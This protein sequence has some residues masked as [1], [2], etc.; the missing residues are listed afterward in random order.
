MKLPEG[1]ILVQFDG[2]CILCSRTI[3]WIMKADR[4]Q[5]F[6][7]Q[8]LPNSGTAEPAESVIVWDRKKTYTHFEAIL[9]IAEELGG[10]YKIAEVLKIIPKRWRH[11][12]YC[13]VSKNRYRWF[14]VRRSCYLPTAEEQQRFL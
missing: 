3:Q 2:L 8:A 12:G 4:Q 9:K 14:G 11:T 6:L 5:K 13:W 1:K 10:I 7:F